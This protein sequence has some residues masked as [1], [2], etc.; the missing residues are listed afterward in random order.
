MKIISSVCSLTLEHGFGEW[1]S[2]K[3]GSDLD[4]DGCEDTRHSSLLMANCLTFG[5]KQPIPKVHWSADFNDRSHY[6]L[7]LRYSAHVNTESPRQEH[8]TDS[9]TDDWPRLMPV[10]DWNQWKAYV[11][12]MSRLSGS[13]YSGYA[14]DSVSNSESEITDGH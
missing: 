12:R 6:L 10:S 1:F 7:C 8:L 5:M 2:G 14:V 4:T 11:E 3:L 13:L 9:V